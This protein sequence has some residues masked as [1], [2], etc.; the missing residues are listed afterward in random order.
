MSIN[1]DIYIQ[2]TCRKNHPLEIKI[3]SPL[4]PL[5]QIMNHRKKYDFDNQKTFSISLENKDLAFAEY[6]HSLLYNKTKESIDIIIWIKKNLNEYIDPI[7]QEILKYIG[8]SME[9]GEDY[10]MMFD[11]CCQMDL[12]KTKQYWKLDVFIYDK[13]LELHQVK[14]DL[15]NYK[16]KYDSLKIYMENISNGLLYYEM[17]DD[18]QKYMNQIR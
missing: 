6:I 5:L 13:I 4:D 18:Y 12:E 9:T 16:S 8:T 15:E 3:D 17:N 7:I 10:S 2:M 1:S 11:M 14:R